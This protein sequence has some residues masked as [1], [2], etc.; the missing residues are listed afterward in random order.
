MTL[1]LLLSYYLLSILLCTYLFISYQLRLFFHREVI[2]TLPEELHIFKDKEFLFKVQRY[3]IYRF[4]LSMLWNCYDDA[5]IIAFT[6]KYKNE[7]VCLFMII[8]Y[9]HITFLMLMLLISLHQNV[10]VGKVPLQ[11][12]VALRWFWCLP[13]QGKVFKLAKCFR[14]FL[15]FQVSLCIIMAKIYWYYLSLGVYIVLKWMIFVLRLKDKWMF[16]ICVCP[17]ALKPLLL[18]IPFV[19]HSTPLL[20]MPNSAKV[21]FFFLFPLLIG[22]VTTCVGW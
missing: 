15:F 5:I 18:L 20:L 8:S 2:E 22:L 16:I 19:T 10:W 6:Q 11:R 12:K 17:S 1:I 9:F 4:L 7:D 13:K 14:T 21:S 3:H